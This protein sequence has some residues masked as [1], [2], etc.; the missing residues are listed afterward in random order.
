MLLIFFYGDMNGR[1]IR[2]LLCTFLPHPIKCLA[3]RYAVS[4]YSI[5]I[6]TLVDKPLA[7]PPPVLRTLAV[8]CDL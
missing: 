6:I 7:M 8:G 3:L 1:E 2:S 4:S 5:D